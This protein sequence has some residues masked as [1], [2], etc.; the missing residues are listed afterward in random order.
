MKNF[1]PNFDPGLFTLA[2][3]AVGAVLVDDFNANEQNSIGNWIIMVGQ[4][5]LTNAAQQQL[6]ESRIHKNNVN[7]NSKAAKSGQS[8][9]TD[10]RGKSNFDTRDEV[11]MLIEA[12]NRI[13]KELE[14]I[15]KNQKNSK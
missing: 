9:F 2:A 12:V 3:V 5:I 14:N 8:F 4:Y 15:K 6:I 1:P 7:I 10:G 11:N 13:S